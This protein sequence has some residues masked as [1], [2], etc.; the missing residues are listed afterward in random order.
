MRAI[1]P[2]FFVFVLAA[3]PAFAG[4]TGFDCAKASSVVEKTLCADENYELGWRDKI[5]AELFR[6]LKENGTESDLAARQSAWLKTRDTC[7]SDADC[8]TKAYDKRLAELARDGGDKAGIT[9]S[10]EYTTADQY[11]SGGI[12]AIRLADGSL[13]GNILTV[14]G[15]SA[16]QCVLDFDSAAPQGKGSWV[17][18]EPEDSAEDPSSLCTIDL[19]GNGKSLKITS[20]NCESFC[21]NAAYFDETYKRVK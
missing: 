11:S 18:T 17:W 1:L 4:E 12:T 3:V 5:M 2:S 10:Y 15:Q 7:G 13:A 19:R 6:Q 9:G 20:K 16:A 14:T 8:L 21:G